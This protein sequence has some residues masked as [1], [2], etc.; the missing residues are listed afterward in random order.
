VVVIGSPLAVVVDTDARERRHTS[1]ALE[2]VGFGVVAVDSFAGAKALLASIAAEIVIADV[3]LGAF[4]GLHLAALCAISRPGLPF[5][6]THES[7]DWVLEC[8]ATRLTALYVVKAPGRDELTR[9]ASTL[10][11]GRQG[12]TGVRRSDRKPAPAETLAQIGASHAYV[13]DVS[14]GGVKL[15]VQRHRSGTGVPRDFFDIKFPALELS[16]RATRVWASPDDATDK[17]LCGADVSQ[18]DI[19][20]LQ[21]WRQFVHSLT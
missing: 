21:R 10:L 7:Y 18:N 14:N 2:R 3:K 1:Q 8:D 20:D 15:K 4:N 16:L 13:V 6:V 12:T 11:E 19:A 9:A 17:W 5:I